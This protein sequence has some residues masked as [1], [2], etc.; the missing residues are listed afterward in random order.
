MEPEAGGRIAQVTIPPGGQ[1]Q[2][3]GFNVKS[4]L[5]VVVVGL[6]VAVSLLSCEA[7]VTSKLSEKASLHPCE[8]TEPEKMYWDRAKVWLSE[9]D[10]QRLRIAWTVTRMGTDARLAEVIGDR[11]KP[12]GKL[13]MAVIGECGLSLSPEDAP[14]VDAIYRMCCATILYGV[15][16]L[17]EEKEI[18]NRWLKVMRV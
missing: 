3:G 1:T 10:F 12:L 5:F 15:T 16:S 6:V 8:L 9:V 2:L 14:E 17:D 4:N 11:Y 18:V 7:R 13:V